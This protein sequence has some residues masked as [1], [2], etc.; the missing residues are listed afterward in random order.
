MARPAA[1]F[2]AAEGTKCAICCVAEVDAV[3][4]PC[5]HAIGCRACIERVREARQGGCPGC[6]RPIREIGTIQ[7]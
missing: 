3:C 2:V 4:L 1:V 6:R 7:L 5:G